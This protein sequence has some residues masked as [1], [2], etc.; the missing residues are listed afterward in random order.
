MD[1]APLHGLPKIKKMWGY[2]HAPDVFNKVDNQWKQI[3]GDGS[4]VSGLLK[5]VSNYK[6]E[7]KFSRGPDSWIS[8]D[9]VSVGI[10]HW[11]AQTMPALFVRFAREKPEIAK[12]A[13][14]EEAAEAMKD[15]QFLV[16]HLNAKR[17][18]GP[19]NK[20]F[21]WLLSGWYEIAR[22][23]EIIQ[24]CADQWLNSY[25]PPS[26]GIMEKYHWKRSDTKAGLI[27]V[28]NSRGAGGMSSMV[29]EAVN[30]LGSKSEKKVMPYL[31]EKLYKKPSRWEKITSWPNFKQPFEKEGRNLLVSTEIDFVS[32]PIVRVDGTVPKFVSDGFLLTCRTE[33]Q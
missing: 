26:C 33:D 9:T 18:K 4:F 13:W 3:T 27:R 7:G 24:I 12:W 28:T 10:A 1:L 31:F 5:L 16:K 25:V 21:D 23:P 22:H 17:G 2:D 15:P 19:H 8:L 29:R 32:A 6:G 11:W 20:K 30:L 14:G